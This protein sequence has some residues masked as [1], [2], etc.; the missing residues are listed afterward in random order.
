M[1]VLKRGF[2]ALTQDLEENKEKI[3]NG[4]TK[5]IEEWIKNLKA[6][7]TALTNDMEEQKDDSNVQA[8]VKK[9]LTEEEKMRYKYAMPGYKAT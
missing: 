3:I 6:A 1:A 9:E 4:D 2:Q 5:G 8:E 7:K